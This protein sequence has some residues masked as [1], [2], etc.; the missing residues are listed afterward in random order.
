VT[1]LVGARS[2]AAPR[3]E[4]DGLL[5]ATQ[6]VSPLPSPTINQISKA[7]NPGGAPWA[8]AGKELVRHSLL[9]PVQPLGRPRGSGTEPKCRVDPNDGSALGSC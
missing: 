6:T 4:E 5:P 7:S 3:P 9:L 2:K 8:C 1:A